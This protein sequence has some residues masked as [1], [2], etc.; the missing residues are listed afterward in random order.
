VLP[1]VALAA[2]L[3]TFFVN[4]HISPGGFGIHGGESVAT[5]E[6]DKND[7]IVKKT[8]RVEQG[9]TVWDWFSLLGV[10]LTL[11]VLGY[12]LQQLQ[13]KKLISDASLQREE[14]DEAAK[15]EALQLYY[16]R[17]STPLIEKILLALP[18]KEDKTEQESQLLESTKD[19]FRARTLSALRRFSDDPKREESVIRFLIETEILSRL[20]VDLSRATI[21][22]AD[23]SGAELAEALLSEASLSGADLS[24]ANLSGADLKGANLSGA[25]MIKANLSGADLSGANLNGSDLSEANLSGANLNGAELNDA[26]LNDAYLEEAFLSEANLRNADLSNADLSNADL[27]GSDLLGV[28]WLFPETKWPTAEAFEGA[29]NLPQQLKEELGLL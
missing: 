9:K 16:D 23:L 15:E 6:K 10:P 26:K 11:A 1:W 2:G 17:L 22:D 5:V 18:A 7:N 12:I 28:K 4:P 21:N 20:G 13:Q 14:A 29:R 25:T 19:I 8:F 24:G 27:S 3:I